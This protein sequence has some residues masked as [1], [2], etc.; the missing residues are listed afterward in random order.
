MPG[1]EEGVVGDGYNSRFVLD[2]ERTMESDVTFPTTTM[3][4]RRDSIYEN[5]YAL[6]LDSKALVVQIENH[7]DLPLLYTLLVSWHSPVRLSPLL[8]RPQLA[9]RPCLWFLPLADLRYTRS[10]TIRTYCAHL[11]RL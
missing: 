1:D 7:I 3:E 11:G 5:R 4:R 9:F 6:D 2:L 8:S 10:P